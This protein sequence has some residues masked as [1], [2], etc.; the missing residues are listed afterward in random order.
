MSHHFM[1]EK[2]KPA[3][4]SRF[5]FLQENH[6]HRYNTKAASMPEADTTSNY[7]GDDEVDKSW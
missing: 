6:R 7:A 1:S 4:L 2:E 3:H 5:I